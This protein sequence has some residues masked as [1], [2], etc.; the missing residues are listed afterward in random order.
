MRKFFM[1]LFVFVVFVSYSYALKIKSK[2]IK[3]GEKIPI[4]FTCDGKDMSPP[5]EFSEI[6]PK[7]KS[8]VLIMDDPDAPM[9]TW[10]HWVVYN[11]PP[12]TKELQPDIPKKKTLKN[13][14]IQGKNSWGKIGYG[15]PCPPK[16]TG[17]H[18]YFFKLYAIDKK[19]N[20]FPGATKKEVLN[21]IKGHIIEQATLM[22]IYKRK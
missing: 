12:S 20:L 14:I 22:G 18:R 3:N 9:G 7:T 13:G 1:I 5:L 11:I 2:A 17:A 6:P 10:V 15:G 4:V 21:A 8:L 16:I 19:L